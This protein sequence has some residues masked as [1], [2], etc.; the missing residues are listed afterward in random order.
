MA[1]QRSFARR[2]ASRGAELE[3]RVNVT[4]SPLLTSLSNA[5][6]RRPLQAPG[7]SLFC[8]PDYFRLCL[9]AET[10][11]TSEARRLGKQKGRE[12]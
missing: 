11:K 12:S 1:A 7:Q 5:E 9:A 6:P 2:A 10:F 8:L 3:T 4:D